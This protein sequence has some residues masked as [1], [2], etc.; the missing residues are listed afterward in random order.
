MVV[1]IDWSI[2]EVA[3]LAGITSRALRHY[4]DIGL[5]TPTRT[6]AN[7]YRHYD[8]AA[9]VRLQRILLLRD[10][11]LRLDDV[12]GVLDREHSAQAALDTHLDWL[13][14]I[15]GTPAY[16]RGLDDDGLRGYVSALAEMYVADPRFA[17][18]YGEQAGAEFV[19]AA[20][21]TYL[22]PLS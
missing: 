1:E 8:Q 20:L 22:A 21:T 4:D 14:D 3:R 19:G 5:L 18:N 6:A 12:G 7:G 15:P 17:A 10:L 16:R 11:G 13:R 2:H 9:L